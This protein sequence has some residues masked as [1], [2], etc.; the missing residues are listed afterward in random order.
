SHRYLLPTPSSATLTEVSAA[1]C[2]VVNL[3]TRK[4]SPRLYLIMASQTDEDSQ[5]LS[6]SEDLHH[7][8]SHNKIF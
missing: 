5:Q 2:E 8:L 7:L 3:R 4:H 1:I 6:T